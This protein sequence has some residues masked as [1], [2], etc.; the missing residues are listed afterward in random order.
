M[1]EDLYIAALLL[2]GGGWVAGCECGE[3]MRMRMR[4]GRVDL[5]GMRVCGS[6]YL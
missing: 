3:A 6:A 1:N 2:A 4:L 5:R